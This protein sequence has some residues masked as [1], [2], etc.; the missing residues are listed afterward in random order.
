MA[1]TSI[2]LGAPGKKTREATPTTPG[3]CLLFD[4]PFLFKF[5][6]PSVE[7]GK[8]G[9]DIF[10]KYTI[11]VLGHNPMSPTDFVDWFELIYSNFCRYHLKA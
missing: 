2:L 7:G 9:M 1:C 5:P 6:L 10:W 8:A 11:S 4:R 3:N